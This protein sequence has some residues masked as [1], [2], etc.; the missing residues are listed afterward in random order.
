MSGSHSYNKE[1]RIILKQ[2]FKYSAVF[3]FLWVKL[4]QIKWSNVTGY[5]GKQYSK[6]K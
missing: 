3:Y 1:F 2:F 4:H 5:K 6:K